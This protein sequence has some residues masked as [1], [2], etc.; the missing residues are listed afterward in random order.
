MP[1]MLLPR[2]ADGAPRSDSCVERAGRGAARG[3][4]LA[5]CA[6]AGRITPG[7]RNLHPR[8]SV[9]ADGVVFRAR[10]A[11]FLGAAGASESVAVPAAAVLR[12]RGARFL[13]AGLDSGA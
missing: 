10:V 9:Q 12:A 1:G 13:G 3:T 6:R 4:A 2:A 5:A 8:P 7:P 11:R